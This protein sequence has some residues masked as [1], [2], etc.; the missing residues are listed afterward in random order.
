MVLIDPLPQLMI[1]TLASFHQEADYVDQEEKTKKVSRYLIFYR[2]RLDVASNFLQSYSN[3]L[4]TKQKKQVNVKSISG[5]SGRSC[6]SA[7][8][9]DYC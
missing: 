3:F 2:H 8:P 1:F 5:T 6:S 4:K 7:C 9:F